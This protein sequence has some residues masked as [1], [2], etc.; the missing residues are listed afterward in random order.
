MA[1]GIRI[2]SAPP[3]FS[4]TYESLSPLLAP[5]RQLRGRHLLSADTCLTY[6]KAHSDGAL[7]AQLPA[8]V[9][10]PSDSAITIAILSDAQVSGRCQ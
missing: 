2:P 4:M 1:G 10:S 9:F 8:Q 5:F 7:T 3:N 6:S